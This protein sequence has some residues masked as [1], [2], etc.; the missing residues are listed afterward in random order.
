MGNATI[1]AETIAQA[2]DS[3]KPGETWRDVATR[4]KMNHNSARRAYSTYKRDLRGEG[5]AQEG[6]RPDPS[7]GFEFVE[8]RLHADAFG[9][10]DRKYTLDEFIAEIGADMTVWQV[11]H[12]EARHY[13]APRK[14]T[15]KDLTFDDGK[16]S[17]SIQDSGRMVVQPMWSY[18]V[19]FVPREAAPVEHALEQVIA[20]LSNVAPRLPVPSYRLSAADYLMV[21][22]L[23]D[24]HFNKRS[25]DGQ[26]T[27]ARAAHDFKAVADAVVAR[28]GK[29]GMSVERIL[30][31]AGN[32]ALHAD[33]LQ[34]TTTDGTWL[35]LAADQR[36]AIDA[37]LDAYEYAVRRLGE[38]AP[39]DVMVVESNHDRLSSFWLGKV[40]A[41]LFGGAE[42][43]T[44]DATNKPRKF[45]RY[46]ATLIGLEHGDKIRPRDLA[47]LMA[48]EAPEEWAM[49]RY[50]EWLRGHV[51][52]SA[53]M[54][55]PITSDSGVTARVIPALCPP[56]VYHVLHGYVGSHRAAEVL[57]Y[58]RDHGP[59]GSF[60]V[61]VD[62]VVSAV[63]APGGDKGERAQDAGES[64]ASWE[65]E[66]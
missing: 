7:P 43:I 1:D 63:P 33:N 18:A 5:P 52:H 60:P 15:I 20:R 66:G 46:G 28:V 25:A 45:Y 31:P 14:H 50:R 57:F 41:A 16:I 35:E 47:A 40:L 62:E 64:R 37:L 48:M 55:Y 6:R 2:Y 22:N 10:S 54:Y 58:H 49:T 38:I 26:Y 44:V 56:D 36:D 59:A 8:H 32:D 51:H 11:A 53:G 9:V 39:V 27:I 19:K 30:F 13:S 29:L 34:G 21:P 3:R 4:L 23:Y 65:G 12:W 24:A 17:G 42:H 61:F